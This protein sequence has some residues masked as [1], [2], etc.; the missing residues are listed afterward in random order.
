M[1]VPG[2]KVSTMFVDYFVDSFKV[3]GTYIIENIS[4]SNM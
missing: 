4:T 3:E 2:V 1:V